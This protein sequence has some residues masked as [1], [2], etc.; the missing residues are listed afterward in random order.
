MM[1]SSFSGR[2][3]G[4][5]NNV[6][7]SGELERYPGIQLMRSLLPLLNYFHSAVPFEIEDLKFYRA[8]S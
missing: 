5:E 2:C 8:N 4:E 7:M 6:P 3:Q 1:L